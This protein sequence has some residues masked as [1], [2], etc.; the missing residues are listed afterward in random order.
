MVYGLWFKAEWWLKVDGVGAGGGIL[1]PLFNK[2]CLL[3]IIKI[4]DTDDTANKTDIEGNIFATLLVAPLC[5]SMR[6]Y[7]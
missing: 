5:T 7:W 4:Y 6:H 3:S 1:K 2:N